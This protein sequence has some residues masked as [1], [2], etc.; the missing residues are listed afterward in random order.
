MWKHPGREVDSDPWL[1]ASDFHQSCRWYVEWPC[2]P[3]T[4][5]FD[6]PFAVGATKPRERHE[7]G[8]PYSY[9]E[10]WRQSCGDGQARVWVVAKNAT[11]SLEIGISRALYCSGRPH[12][13]LDIRFS[14]GRLGGRAKRGTRAFTCNSPTTRGGPGPCRWFLLRSRHTKLR[15]GT[16]ESR[17]SASLIV[18]VLSYGFESRIVLCLRGLA[19]VVM[20]ACL[21]QGDYV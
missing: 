19:N 15:P 16:G 17:Y 8:L 5:H 9:V 11:L 2:C 4:T 1:I 7:L 14:E 18:G 21:A 10:V 3:P 13:S 20:P 6:A 12:A